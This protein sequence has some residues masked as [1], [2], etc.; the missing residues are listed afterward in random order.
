ME[1]VKIGSSRVVYDIGNNKILKKPY[2]AFGIEQSKQEWKK[3]K[4][5]KYTNLLATIYDFDKTTGE[6]IMEKLH[7]CFIDC[8]GTMKEYL[9][10]IDNNVV[11]AGYDINGNIKL[12]DYGDCAFKNIDTKTLINGFD[13][14]TINKL[15]SK[16]PDTKIIRGTL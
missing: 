4:K 3:W 2:T 10:L 1:H 15:K 12:F 8:T 16:L 13:E 5:F 6:I 7:N 11:Q 9:A 14:S